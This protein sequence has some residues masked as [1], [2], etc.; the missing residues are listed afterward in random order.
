MNAWRRIVGI[1]AN[2]EARA[3]YA[4]IVLGEP[5]TEAA[6]GLRER[7]LG[8]VLAN[9]VDSG[10]VREDSGVLVATG[11]LF[12]SML[13]AEP[14][15]QATGVDRFLR[16]GRIE[17]YPASAGERR[18]LLEWVVAEA[19]A[20]GDELSE[21]DVNERLARFTDDVAVLRR[22]LVDHELLERTP[23]GSTYAPVAR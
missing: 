21:G 8:R 12:R 20:P 22:Y 15:Q 2:D 4:R 9:L 1:L 19:F 5:V 13:A 11:D 16:D 6:T 10:L 14:A 3:V 7:R 17:Q 23:S 18:E